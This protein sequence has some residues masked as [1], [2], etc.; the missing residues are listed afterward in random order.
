[1]LNSFG[2]L[3]TI[4]GIEEDSGDDPCDSPTKKFKTGKF[5]SKE[6]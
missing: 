1:M 4:F 3:Q 6:M 2:F 5:H